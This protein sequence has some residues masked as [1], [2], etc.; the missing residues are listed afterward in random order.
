[1]QNWKQT[2]LLINQTLTSKCFHFL[3]LL[4][5]LRCA[6]GPQPKCNSHLIYIIICRNSNQTTSI[7]FFTVY[8]FFFSFCSIV[9]RIARCSQRPRCIRLF[10]IRGIFNGTKLGKRK[11][12]RERAHPS[13]CVDAVW[14]TKDVRNTH[15]R[16]SC[17]ADTLIAH[18][19]IEY[20]FGFRRIFLELFFCSLLISEKQTYGAIFG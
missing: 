2:D 10:Q 12:E 3:L 11:I 7:I 18:I 14:C 17:D 9:F 19:C 16:N 20:G 8:F 4:F 13:M 6:I 5:G 1:M 15:T